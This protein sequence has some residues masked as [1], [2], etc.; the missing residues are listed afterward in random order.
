MIEPIR[1]PAEEAHRKV[2]AREAILVCAYEDEAKFKKL[3]LQDA[4]SLQEFMTRIPSLSKE[5][6]IIFYC[7]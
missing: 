5:Q 6:E 1:I 4:I 3:H 7:A 2:T